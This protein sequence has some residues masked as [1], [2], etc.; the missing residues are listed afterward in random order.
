[1][2]CFFSARP[3]KLRARLAIAGIWCVAGA[4][5][6]PMAAAL[7]VTY[8][9]DPDQRKFWRGRDHIQVP[10]S[11][12]RNQFQESTTNP[13]AHTLFWKSCSQ[14]NTLISR[15]MLTSVFWRSSRDQNFFSSYCIVTP[16]PCRPD[17]REREQFEIK[18]TVIVILVTVAMPS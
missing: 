3:S 9:E 5:A 1:M 4:L 17:I 13:K 12:F 2:C 16:N 8:I 15:R 11:C 14:T 18:E 7:R 10:L 6:A